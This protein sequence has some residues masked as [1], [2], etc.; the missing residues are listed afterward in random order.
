MV[1]RSKY[2]WAILIV[3]FSFF[4]SWGLI[5]LSPKIMATSQPPAGHCQV[6]VSK[7]SVTV[8]EE[9]TVTVVSSDP[10]GVAW[11]YYYDGADERWSPWSACG[12]VD[13]CT[14][15]WRAALR[16]PGTYEYKGGFYNNRSAWRECGPVL[17]TATGRVAEKPKP[18]D[19]SKCTLEVD[20]KVVGEGERF[21]LTISIE[22]SAGI[23]YAYYHDVRWSTH[24]PCGNAATCVKSFPL[25]KNTVGT[26]EF[27]GAYYD[28]QGA[29]KHCPKVSVSVV[30]DPGQATPPNGCPASTPDPSCPVPT[31]GDLLSCSGETHN[32]ITVHYG[33]GQA[34]LETTMEVHLY[35]NGVFVMNLGT[36]RI[37]GS[38][39]DQ[40]LEPQQEYL[41]SLVCPGCGRDEASR[42]IASKVC[43][44]SPA[45]GDQPPSVGATIKLPQCPFQDNTASIWAKHAR[46]SWDAKHRQRLS[47]WRFAQTGQY[48]HCRWYWPFSVSHSHSTPAVQSLWLP[49]VGASAFHLCADSSA[50]LSNVPGCPFSDGGQG[51]VWV[52]PEMPGANIVPWDAAKCQ[53]GRDCEVTRG[54]NIGGGSV[55]L[56]IKTFANDPGR[57]WGAIVART[58]SGL[59]IELDLPILGK[60]SRELKIG[61]EFPVDVH[62]CVV[63]GTWV[64]PRVTSQPKV[65]TL[66]VK[67]SPGSLPSMWGRLV[68]MGG[69][70][71]GLVY[72]EYGLTPQ[73]E[74]GTTEQKPTQ[75]LGEF[76]SGI[77]GLTQAN[78]AEHSGRT[79]HYR[80]VAVNQL[81]RVQGEGRSFVVG[82]PATYTEQPVADPS[83]GVTRSE[84]TMRASKSSVGMGENFTLTIEA[85]DPAGVSTIHYRDAQQNW[86]PHQG[87]NNAKQCTKT[88]SLS[89]TAAGVYEFRSGFFNAQNQWRDC[90]SVRV[91]VSA[92][93]TV[94]PVPAPTPTPTPPP[95]TGVMP[96]TQ[97]RLP[98]CPFSDAASIWVKNAHCDWGK[99]VS[100][101]RSGQSSCGLAGVYQT[102]VGQD[103]NRRPISSYWA[104]LFGAS[105]L[106]MCTTAD[107]NISNLAACPFGDGGTGAVWVKPAIPVLTIW[108]SFRCQVGQPCSR[109]IKITD[110]AKL[111]IQES[112]GASLRQAVQQIASQ[113]LQGQNFNLE[114]D[115]SKVVSG[116]IPVEFRLNTS[117]QEPG[118]SHGRIFV[119]SDQELELCAAQGLCVKIPLEFN[120]VMPLD[121]CVVGVPTTSTPAPTPAPAPAPAPTPA[122]TP[123]SGLPGSRLS[124]PKCSFSDAAGIWAKHA[125]CGWNNR[126]S[127]D[128]GGSAS[129]GLMGINYLESSP[130]RNQM[131]VIS[132]YWRPLFGASAFDLCVMTDQNVPNLTNCPFNEGGSG[133]VWVKPYIPILNAWTSFRCQ[134]GRSCS[135]ELNLEQFASLLVGQTGMNL[136]QIINRIKQEVL[137]GQDFDLKVNLEDIDIIFK[138]STSSGETGRANGRVGIETDYEV[139]ICVA[140]NVCVKLPLKFDLVMPLNY[141][142]VG[143]SS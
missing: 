136:E 137:D 92:T 70:F 110:L 94:T 140:E 116:E 16:S 95:T 115:L 129:C 78:L 13:S 132:S 76:H 2:L 27:A 49:L 77:P 123:V 111:L 32:S 120:F 82:G 106:D 88:F 30:K 36:G 71:G 127:T 100:A 84:C 131:P 43:F 130:S 19:K 134:L 6:T 81:G 39:E 72:F 58:G 133:S 66:G 113:L 143:A 99:R 8:G 35:R 114:I 68:D 18:S 29:L 51:T 28:S 5:E 38:K 22:D 75:S 124:L 67:Q 83:V 119:D 46:C 48:E 90:A 86:A 91:A 7:T 52:K 62:V 97:V 64:P 33:S 79:Y 112:V 60:I 3:G 102:R 41:Y 44:T 117:S 1:K 74:L 4:V 56:T 104:P 121:Y 50:N 128:R 73:Y 135:K 96:G 45:P 108:T 103:G 87:C 69:S 23:N 25:S 139:E 10:T 118:R 101:L 109:S 42:T 63:G 20:K 93:P 85:Q 54:F 37:R 11:A 59:M 53:M 80:A 89:R 9:F 107:Q 98:A 122:P 105:Q 55:G 126:A 15:T 31:A 21:N 24:H 12:R 17:V 34:M 141:C 40:G 142:V 14:R 47:G 57:A 138:L 125:Q 61:L 65:E 26:Y